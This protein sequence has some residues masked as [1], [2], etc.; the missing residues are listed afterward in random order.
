MAAGEGSKLD[1]SCSIRPSCIVVGERLFG[2]E[3]ERKRR[4]VENF[5]ERELPDFGSGAWF[6]E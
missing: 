3:L 2:L 5:L 1:E 6:E 4:F